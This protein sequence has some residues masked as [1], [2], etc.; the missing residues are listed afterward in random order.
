MSVMTSVLTVKIV[1][2]TNVLIA[3]WQ[4]QCSQVYSLHSEDVSDDKCAH[5]ENGD[6][7]KCTHGIVTSVLSHSENVSDDKCTT[8]AAIL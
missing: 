6:D 8:A 4:H 2:M 1:V 5:S 3:W 7:D